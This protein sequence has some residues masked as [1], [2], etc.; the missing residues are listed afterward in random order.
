MAKLGKWSSSTECS[1]SGKP[2]DRVAK[3]VAGPG[4]YICNECIE[5][6]NDIMDMETDHPDAESSGAPGVTRRG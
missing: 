6:C 3:L 4:V 5:L 2:P 1:F